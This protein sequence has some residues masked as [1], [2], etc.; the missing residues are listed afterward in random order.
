MPSVDDRMS[1][2]WSVRGWYS[3]I[4]TNPRHPCLGPPI[5]NPG[6]RQVP[7][8]PPATAL[9]RAKFWLEVRVFVDCKRKDKHDTNSYHLA[10]NRVNAEIQ[11]S[12][13][14]RFW[15]IDCRAT[16]DVKQLLQVAPGS[17]ANTTYRDSIVAWPVFVQARKTFLR[18]QH[19]VRCPAWNRF[20]LE[21][22]G[23][24]VGQ[25]HARTMAAN[26][27]PAGSP[28]TG[29]ARRCGATSVELQVSEPTFIILKLEKQQRPETG[30]VELR[31][32]RRR[33]TLSAR[34]AS[35]RRSE[36]PRARARCAWVRAGLSS[37]GQWL[38]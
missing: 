14:Y 30:H 11:A 2:P 26:L 34:M 21:L 29:P 22:V 27:A 28:R 3:R 4:S 12:F 1:M 36:L 33:H 13:I 16:G 23:Q 19:R 6:T 7:V 15:R 24:Q 17:D 10:S 31:E 35:Q 20:G 18:R 5:R 37:R 32:R 25:Q 38:N 8:R 9:R